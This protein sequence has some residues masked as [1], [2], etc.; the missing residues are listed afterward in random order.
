MNMY[1]VHYNILFTVFLLV[2]T[3]VQTSKSWNELVS[4]VPIRHLLAINFTN[5]K[6]GELLMEYTKT[7]NFQV[8]ILLAH[9]DSPRIQAGTFLSKL[10]A[11]DLVKLSITP[12][13]VANYLNELQEDDLYVFIFN[14]SI[15]FFQNT[16][17]LYAVFRALETDFFHPD[18][19]FI[20]KDP[21]YK[22][23]SILK[24][25]RE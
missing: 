18:P 14:Y 9:Q 1:T 19:H 13:L 4:L 8:K 3:N 12:T 11:M 15:L 10:I 2:Q 16:V 23:T 20:R 17:F 21:E 24:F 6:D 25:R 22:C 7:M 5:P